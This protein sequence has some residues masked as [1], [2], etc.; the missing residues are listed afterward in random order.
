MVSFRTCCARQS[1]TYEYIL[2]HLDCCYYSRF[3]NRRTLRISASDAPKYAFAFCLDRGPELA[4]VSR[5]VG[6]VDRRIVGALLL[7]LVPRIDA[8]RNGR[9]T[10]HRLALYRTTILAAVLSDQTT[11]C[12]RLPVNPIRS[13]KR[14]RRDRERPITQSRGRQSIATMR[15]STVQC[16]QARQSA[17]PASRA[18][19]RRAA[20]Q[21]NR[22]DRR[23][24]KTRQ[25]PT[26][27]A[28]QSRRP[29][30]KELRRVRSR[31]ISRGQSSLC[32]G[33]FS[34]P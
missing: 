19:R 24:C 25:A 9:L 21:R 13:M 1:S 4:L 22:P 11:F 2:A 14:H 7:E 3:Y 5:S 8:S 18:D 34:S 10:C 15:A 32:L 23:A 17:V 28:L 26:R 27:R 31:T 12:R 20:R 29:G 6:N 30:H 16:S 33:L